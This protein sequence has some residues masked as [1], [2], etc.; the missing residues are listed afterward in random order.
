MMRIPALVFL[1]ALLLGPALAQD[2]APAA[3][4]TAP[5]GTYEMN[6]LSSVTLTARRFL[7]APLRASFGTVAGTMVVSDE[8]STLNQLG[9]VITASDLSANG[10]IVEGMLLGEGFLN[11]EEHPLIHFAAGDFDVSEAP[12]EVTGPL[13][14]AGVTHPATFTTR[15]EGFEE[16]LQTGEVRLQFVAEGEI[17]RSDWGMSGYRRLVAN[18][19]TVR[20]ETEFFLTPA[21]SPIE[22]TSD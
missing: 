7:M 18:K 16:D 12:N 17:N 9:V 20:I 13:T 19:T 22:E 8:G 11:V 1:S 14:M 4:W 10:P 2:P 21:R 15:L 3:V 5:P 6:S